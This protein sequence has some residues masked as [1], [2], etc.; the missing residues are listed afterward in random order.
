ME[1]FDLKK[2]WK[3]LYEGK[4]G[5]IVTVNVPPLNYLMIDGE[6]DPNTSRSFQEAVEALYS[7]SYTLKFSLKKSPEA[8][9]YGVMPLEGLWWADD[10]RDFGWVGQKADKSKWKWTAMIVQPQFI[11]QS[12]VDVAFEEL[13]RKK[14]PAAL[15]RVRFEALE[16]GPSAQVLYLAPF[17]NEGPTIQRMHD[18]IHAS[19][20]ELR[21]KHHEIYLSD[22]RHTAPEKLKTILRQSMR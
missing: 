17:A 5:V 14:N 21:G 2:Q 1:K 6:G 13:R 15:D 3:Q 18:F 8:I 12:E 7:L 11:A 19:G 10:P 22:P 20:K 16:E 4:A 9:D